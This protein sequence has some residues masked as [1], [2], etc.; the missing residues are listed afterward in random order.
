MLT[1][2]VCQW[3]DKCVRQQRAVSLLHNWNF[4]RNEV[5]ETMLSWV[6]RVRSP[7]SNDMDRDQ[8]AQG[9]GSR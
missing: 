9:A 5:C 2:N 1:D 7:V 3:I 8:Q 4:R 6:T